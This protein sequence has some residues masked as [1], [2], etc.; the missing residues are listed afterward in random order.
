MTVVLDLNTG[1]AGVD[2]A[3]SYTANSRNLVLFGAASVSS[4]SDKA[5][6]KIDLHNAADNLTSLLKANFIL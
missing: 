6:F 4:A 2:D 1:L 5:D 3:S